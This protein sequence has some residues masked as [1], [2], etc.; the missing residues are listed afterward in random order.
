[1]RGVNVPAAPLPEFAQPA[2][3]SASV[4]SIATRAS[5]H[6]E[7]AAGMSAL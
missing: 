4:V 1:M 3:E 5:G 6:V 2:V 7:L